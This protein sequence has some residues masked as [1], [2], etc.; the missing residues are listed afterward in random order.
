MASIV[1]PGAG[2][3]GGG[4]DDVDLRAELADDQVRYSDKIFAVIFSARFGEPPDAY[5][6]QYDGVIYELD[7]LHIAIDQNQDAGCG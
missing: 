7:H 4:G 3:D 5:S 2:A 6:L 1:R